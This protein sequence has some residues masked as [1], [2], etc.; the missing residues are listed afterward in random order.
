[1]ILVRPPTSAA[2][3]GKMAKTESQAAASADTSTD[4]FQGRLALTVGETL[5]ALRISRSGFYEAVA[6]GV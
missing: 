3:R 4:P 1:M 2:M 6:R 5:I